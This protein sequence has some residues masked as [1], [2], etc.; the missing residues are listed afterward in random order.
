MNMKIKRMTYTKDNGEVSRR[1]V[2]VISAPRDNYLCYDITNI[3]EKERK[4]LEHYLDSI[5]VYRD[6]TFEELKSIT[7]IRQNALWRSFKPE[8]I[9]WEKDND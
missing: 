2:I 7:G 5:D 9:E 1:A 6:E 3:G 8:G 4:I